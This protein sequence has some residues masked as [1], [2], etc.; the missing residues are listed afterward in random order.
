MLSH[1]V[2]RVATTPLC[3]SLVEQSLNLFQHSNASLP[4]EGPW[5]RAVGKDE[6]SSP[7]T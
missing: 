4:S 7:Q 3:A 2:S 5:S 1:A 6:H